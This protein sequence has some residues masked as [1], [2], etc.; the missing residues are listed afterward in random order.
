MIS[1]EGLTDYPFGLLGRAQ[2]PMGLIGLGFLAAWATAVRE[3]GGSAE[4]HVPEVVN[5]QRER[6]ITADVVRPHRFRSFLE[7][8]EQFSGGAWIAQRLVHRPRRFALG[9]SQ[10][11]VTAR[12]DVNSLRWNLR[13]RTECDDR[14]DSGC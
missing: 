14:P 3:L 1:R 9:R 5:R 12:P 8:R 4:Y 2:R 7:A 10:A 13:L 11:R 6:P